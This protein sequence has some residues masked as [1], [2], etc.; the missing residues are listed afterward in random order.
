MFETNLY[1]QTGLS[2][3]VHSVALILSSVPRQDLEFLISVSAILILTA[4]ELCKIKI[5][6]FNCKH[7][8]IS[9]WKKVNNLFS[10]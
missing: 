7:Q 9:K 6:V 2:G 5:I 1:V 3:R 10:F 8:V 4:L